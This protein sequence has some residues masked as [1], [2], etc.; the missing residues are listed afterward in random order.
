MNKSLLLLWYLFWFYNLVTNFLQFLQFIKIFLNPLVNERVYFQTLNFF[1]WFQTLYELESLLL[2]PSQLLNP[3]M[4]YHFVC[5][6]CVK[7]FRYISYF[8]FW[9]HFQKCKL[10]C[11]IISRHYPLTKLIFNKS[12]W[13]SLNQIDNPCS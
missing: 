13:Y 11:F 2:D 3:I 6:R 7:N 12:K 9:S 1:K 8:V 10:N 4:I 5:F